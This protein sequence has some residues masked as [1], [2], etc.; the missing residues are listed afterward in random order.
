VLGL[1]AKTGEG[2]WPCPTGDH[3]GPGVDAA[4]CSAPTAAPH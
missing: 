1:L 3:P 2:A 4:A